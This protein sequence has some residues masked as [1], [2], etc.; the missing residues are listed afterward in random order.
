MYYFLFQLY[1]YSH[2]PPNRILCQVDFLITRYIILIISHIRSLIHVDKP[3][4]NSF[5]RSM[6]YHEPLKNFKRNSSY[7]TRRAFLPFMLGAC[8]RR[9]LRRVLYRQVLQVSTLR[10]ISECS[11]NFY[12]S[13]SPVTSIEISPFESNLKYR[14]IY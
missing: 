6:S 4:E 7:I 13:I 5:L 11:N 2:F 10:V 14:S 9:F 12:Q 8:A 1:N 3:E